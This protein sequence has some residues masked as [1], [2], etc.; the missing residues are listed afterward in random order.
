[1]QHVA[2]I[3]RNANRFHARHGFWPMDGWL[4]AFAGLGLVAAD[5]SEALVLR[6]LPS[7]E[8]IAAARLPDSRP[9]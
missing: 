7:P 3:V 6:R 9:F 5:R 1:V 4:D 8:E 2:D